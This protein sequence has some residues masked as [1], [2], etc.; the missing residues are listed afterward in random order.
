MYINWGRLIT[1]PQTGKQLKTCPK[2]HP[3]YLPN[4]FQIS[5]KSLPGTF[6]GAFKKKTAFLRL[7]G[8]PNDTKEAPE[9]L[10]KSLKIT[11]YQR[12]EVLKIH[13]KTLLEKHMENVWSE[14]PWNL[15]NRAETAARAQFSHS[16]LITEKCSTCV[17]KHL[18]W[19]PWAHKNRNTRK[20]MISEKHV[21]NECR[22]SHQKCSIWTCLSMERE[23]RLINA[24]LSTF[25]R[26]SHTSVHMHGG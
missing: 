24:T 23:A 3:K 22:N 1:L 9:R 20:K 26:H 2:T 11:K 6:L 17:K 8:C 7:F 18:L 13:L 14:R 4:P 19:T 12:S 21:K 5:F 10:P 25:V 16:R 15:L